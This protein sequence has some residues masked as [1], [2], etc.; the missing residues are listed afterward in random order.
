MD[1]LFSRR[2][3]KTFARIFGSA[4]VHGIYATDSRRLSVRAAFPGI[5]DAEE[6]GRGSIV[7]GF[8]LPGK[9]AKTNV[10]ENYD[11]G[12]TLNMMRGVSVYSFK[13]GMETLTK[14]MEDALLASKN[15]EIL[16]NTSVSGLKCLEDLS[17]E[18]SRNIIFFHFFL[19]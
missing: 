7:R 1:S 17:F 13:D 3:G 11:L 14:A 12:N 19:T 6:R 5:W 16:S 18:V 9:K 2:F 8:L 15:V 4:L 10:E